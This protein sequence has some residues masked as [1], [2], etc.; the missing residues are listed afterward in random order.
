MNFDKPYHSTSELI[1]LLE[2]RGIIIDDPDFAA[3]AIE[4]HSYYTIVNGYKNRFL[5]PDGKAYAP[6]VKFSDLYNMHMIDTGLS[7]ILFKYILFAERELKNRI[8]QLIASKYGVFTDVSDKSNCS[9]NDYL[10]RYYYHNCRRRNNILLRLKNSMDPSINHYCNDIVLH[11]RQHHNH[12]PPWIMATNIPFGLAIE[13]YYILS[14]N[15]KKS[16]CTQMLPTD[17][18]ISDENQKSNTIQLSENGV[19][20]TFSHTREPNRERNTFW[21]CA[22]YQIS[23]Y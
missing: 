10:C 16:I 22:L 15:D 11:Y 7:S 13:W 8:S 1:H 5:S 9:R 17:S 3:T 20:S 12:I 23:S 6:G 14:P 21:S 4:S 18:L 19:F 2:S